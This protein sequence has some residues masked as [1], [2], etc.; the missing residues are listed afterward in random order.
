MA[1]TRKRKTTAQLQ[2]KRRPT[3]SLVKYDDLGISLS[4]LC[5]YGCAL[6]HYQVRP[7]VRGVAT[8]GVATTAGQC[9]CWTRNPREAQS[10]PLGNDMLGISLISPLCFGCLLVI[11]K[12]TPQYVVLLQGCI[13]G[14]TDNTDNT[15]WQKLKCKHLIFSI[16]RNWWVTCFN[17][18]LRIVWQV[19]SALFQ[20]WLNGHT[21]Y[22]ASGN[23]YEN[24]CIH[25]STFLWFSRFWHQIGQ[26]C[27]FTE[28]HFRTRELASRF[29]LAEY[30]FVFTASRLNANTTTVW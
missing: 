25:V 24:I 9:S 29:V 22:T 10:I 30:F 12:Y 5:C 21:G 20:R 4:R 7:T 28:K 3:V 15:F 14:C 17:I 23:K 27:C 8:T 1:M 26:S 11:I 2:N 18:L 6:V 16:C 13:L 19:R